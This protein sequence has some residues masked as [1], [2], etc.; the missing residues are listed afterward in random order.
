MGNHLAK[1][2]VYIDESSIFV[3]SDARYLNA[4]HT[5]DLDESATDW[6]YLTT[7]DSDDAPYLDSFVD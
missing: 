5:P 2:Y 4:E 6:A 1:H 7:D 3:G